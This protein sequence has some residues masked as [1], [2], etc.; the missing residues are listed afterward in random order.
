VHCLQVIKLLNLE[1]GAVKA[2]LINALF[3]FH[4]VPQ[5]VLF[6]KK[7]LAGCVSLGS[8]EKSLHDLLKFVH[9]LVQLVLVGK[10]L[11]P[12]LVEC[13]VEDLEERFN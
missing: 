3:Y 12:I 7:E 5:N 11:S 2:K 13:L 1:F 10:D 6:F 9:L 8:V 4:Y